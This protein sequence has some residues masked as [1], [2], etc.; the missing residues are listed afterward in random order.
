MLFLSLQ[1]PFQFFTIHDRGCLTDDYVGTGLFADAAFFDL[2]CEF[3]F[4]PS[5]LFLSSS[6]SISL[7]LSVQPSDL[8]QTEPDRPASPA[9]FG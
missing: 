7:S 4:F 3:L 9:W 8:G 5:L 1:A 6:P 2:E